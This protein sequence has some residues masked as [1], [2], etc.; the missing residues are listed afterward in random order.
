M[1]IVTALSA[2]VSVA[3]NAR[4]APGFSLPDLKGAERDLQDY[5][6]K[7]VILDI[8]RATCPHCGAFAKVLEQVQAS[9]GGKVAVLAI[10][11]PPDDQA[12][13]AR[14]VVDMKITYPVLFD[15]G[16]VAFSYIL[17]D[18]LHGPT[19]KVPHAYLIDG[20]GIIRGDW[21]YDTDTEASFEAAA[22]HREIDKLLG[23][24][25]AAKH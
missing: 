8:M 2:G 4:R 17:P 20:N 15:C 14:F 16:Q 19:V 12:A 1:A 7:I 13:V 18:P 10:T 22:L 6:G 25:A 21:E 3:Q 23:A 5:R 24:K 11:N 9:Y